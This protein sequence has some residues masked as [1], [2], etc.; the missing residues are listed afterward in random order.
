M[1]MGTE[2]YD[3]VSREVVVSEQRKHHL[4]DDQIRTYT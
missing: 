3:I 4:I 1:I 2:L